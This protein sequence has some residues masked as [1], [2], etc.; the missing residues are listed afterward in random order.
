LLGHGILGGERGT[1]RAI[2]ET[3]TTPVLLSA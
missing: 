1:T 3:M 2:L